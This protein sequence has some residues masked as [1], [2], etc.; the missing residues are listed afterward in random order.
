MPGQVAFNPVITAE[1]KA[2]VRARW[3]NLGC[4]D[5]GVINP[6][7]KSLRKLS[8]MPD[9]KQPERPRDIH[10]VVNTIPALAWSARADGFPDFFNQRRLEYTGLTE[11]QALDGGW[12]IVIHLD[13]LPRVQDVFQQAVNQARSFEVEGRLR[14]SDGEYR[15]SLFRGAPVCDEFGNVVKW[16][17]TN[18]D[19]EG[20]KD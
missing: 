4:R 6:T 14:R 20:L 9:A 2:E 19:L 7:T 17:G 16:Y 5:G 3:P 11:E 1:F 8:Q 15:C 10:L 13:D 18:T 12:K